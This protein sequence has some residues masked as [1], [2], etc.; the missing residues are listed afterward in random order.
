[1]VLNR[2]VCH[3]NSTSQVL[4]TF[5]ILLYFSKHKTLIFGSSRK[6]ENETNISFKLQIVI[7]HIFN[8]FINYS[9]FGCF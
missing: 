4:F 7:F 8:L 9:A 6:W 1:M 2:S 3:A 5:N